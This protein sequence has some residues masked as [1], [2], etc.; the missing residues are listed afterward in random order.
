VLAEQGAD[1]R[2]AGIDRR[3]IALVDGRGK[4]GYPP[5]EAVLA[6]ETRI[7]RRG[8]DKTRRDREFRQA[9]LAQVDGLAA[10][11][12]QRGDFVRVRAHAEETDQGEVGFRGLLGGVHRDASFA[13]AETRP[14]LAVAK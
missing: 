9:Q 8:D 10:H 1:L 13:L 11:F 6:D 7:G 4:L 3:R 5:A 2:G 12:G 14:F